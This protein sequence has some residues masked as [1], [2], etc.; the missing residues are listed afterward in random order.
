MAVKYQTVMIR[1]I[2][3]NRNHTN[4]TPTTGD[5]YVYTQSMFWTKLR[6]NNERFYYIVRHKINL[7]WNCGIKFF[8]LQIL[9]VETL[10]LRILNDDSLSSLSV[11]RNS[12]WRPRCQK[13]KKIHILLYIVPLKMNKMFPHNF[14]RYYH[15]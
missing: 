7:T 1:E 6:E 4:F 8:S 12:R 9:V 11:F 15:I 13:I 2:K 14:S 5:S 10:P 3:E